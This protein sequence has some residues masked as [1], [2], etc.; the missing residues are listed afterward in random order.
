[1]VEEF[2]LSDS[3]KVEMRKIYSSGGSSYIIT[4][5]KRWV[6]ENNLKVGD[7]VIMKISEDTITI[8]V[9]KDES[10][11]K[12]TAIIDAKDLKSEFLIRRIISYY[13]A[14]YD[15]LRVKVYNEDHRRAV[16][17]ASDILI[18]AEIIED[19]GDEIVF[20]IFLDDSRFRPDDII[21]KM[22]NI[23]I[24]MVSDFCKVAKKLDRYICSSIQVRENEVDRLHFL[25]LR[26]LKKAVK[27]GSV[28]IQPSKVLEYRTV[29][30]AYERIADHCAN[31]AESLLRIER[32]IPEFCEFVDLVLSMLK[33][34]SVSFLR[35][36]VELADIVLEEFDELSE[37][38]KEY[39]RLVI[40]DN[41]EVSLQLKTIFNSLVR[42]AGYSADIAEVVINMCVP[43]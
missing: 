21:E 30:R 28:D 39:Y 35:R 9:R 42:V 17:L 36:D 4:L 6:E 20:E 12:K 37:K 8:T 26:L 41:V 22:G 43:D 38:E 11:V 13:L 3:M 27:G 23:C 34:A 32:P 25:A 2:G 15:T 24:S 14:G 31:M 18:G 33:M 5:P 1:L 10:K 7:T 29:V 40:S 19:L 16:A